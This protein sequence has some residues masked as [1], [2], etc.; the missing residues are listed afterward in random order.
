MV[1]NGLVAFAIFTGKKRTRL[2]FNYEADKAAK[3]IELS[4]TL[5]DATP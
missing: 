2:L 5:E 4:P 1:T 3:E